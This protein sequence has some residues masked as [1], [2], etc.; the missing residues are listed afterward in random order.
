MAKRN[1]KSSFFS[2]LSSQRKIKDLDEL[3]PKKITKY[4][5]SLEVLRLMRKSN[6]TL[7]KASRKVQISPS[8]VK[9][10]VGSALQKKNRRIIARKNDNLLRKMRIYEEGKEV[11]V[12]VKGNKTAEKI[13][14]FQG[15]IGEFQTQGK[16]NALQDFERETI[17]DKDGKLHR[18]ETNPDI[19]KEIIER[20]EEPEFFSVYSGGR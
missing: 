9:R 16:S 11:W 4:E 6:I 3:P 2:F 14:R 18:F 8:T 17:R 5:D 10:N 13:N 1:A 15:T 12:Q 7:T 19:I 20:R